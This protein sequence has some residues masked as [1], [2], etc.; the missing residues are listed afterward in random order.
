MIS[1]QAVGRLVSL[2]SVATNNLQDLKQLRL[3]Q[4]LKRKL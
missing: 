2:A 1:K 4:S 3:G